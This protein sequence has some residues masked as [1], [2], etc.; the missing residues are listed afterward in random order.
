MSPVQC[1]R[2]PQL[3]P[4]RTDTYPDARSNAST[5]PARHPR[6]DSPINPAT[7]AES[8]ASAS[9]FR[10][11][12]GDARETPS[13]DRL[14]AFLDEGSD[15]DGARVS[16]AALTR[17]MDAN[18]SQAV[19]SPQT[20]LPVPS[21]STPPPSSPRA[22]RPQSSPRT[23]QAPPSQDSDLSRSTSVHPASVARLFEAQGARW[24]TQNETFGDGIGDST[25]L[26]GDGSRRTQNVEREAWNGEE[27]TAGKMG[28]PR[29]VVEDDVRTSTA[30]VWVIN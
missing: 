29:S 7:Q 10:S 12:R 25:P 8:P 30:P 11:A 13:L 15:D 22:A 21:T 18:L 2:Y 3:T 28:T 27:T 20:R 14:L 16:T 26:K 6:G 24:S 1:A 19:A 4:A 9:S 5:G 23:R 17:A